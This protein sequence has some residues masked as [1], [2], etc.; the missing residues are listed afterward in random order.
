M[1]VRRTLWAWVYCA[2]LGCGRCRFEHPKQGGCFFR[3]FS[4]CF[5]V[6]LGFW[7]CKFFICAGLFRCFCPH[8]RG[9]LVCLFSSTSRWGSCYSFWPNHPP[10]GAPPPRHHHSLH[11]EPHHHSR[12]AGNSK[13]WRVAGRRRA[14]RGAQTCWRA[15]LGFRG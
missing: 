13:P 15:G 10:P 4:C 7:G 9:V 12:V 1:A 11:H 6:F 5:C 14:L 3:C 8:H 2:C